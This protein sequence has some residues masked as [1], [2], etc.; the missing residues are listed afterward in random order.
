MKIAE[1]FILV[2]ITLVKYNSKL[3]SVKLPNTC[4][5]TCNIVLYSALSTSS[6][7]KHLLRARAIGYRTDSEQINDS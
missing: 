5:D 1:K 4:Y 2:M 6:A 7:V 3:G